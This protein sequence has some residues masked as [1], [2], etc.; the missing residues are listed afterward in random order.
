MKKKI[1]LM[2]V[3]T[4]MLVLALTVAVSADSV[5]TGKVDLNQKVTLSD[6]TECALFDADGD[7]LIWYKDANGALQSIKAQDE[8][9][10][11]YCT[12]QFGVGNS[13]VGSVTVYE[14]SKIEIALESGTLPCSS[15]VVFNI[16]D[17]DVLSNAGGSRLNNPVNCIRSNT[18][19][20]ST[21]LEYAFLRLD[22]G[23]IQA[24]AFQGCSNLKYVNLEHLTELRQFGGGSCFNNCKSFMV[25]EVLDLSNTKL[26]AILGTGTFN[27]VKLK[28]IILP[29]TVTDLG[30]WNLQG[31]SLESFVVPTG[32]TKISGST[33]N[34]T[35]T[36]KTIYI[37]NT[38]TSI[39]DRA[40]NNTGLEKIFYVGTLDQLN[41]LLAKASKTSNDPFWAVVGENNA[42]VISYADYKN[43]EDKSGKYV[44][45]NY[46][47]CEAYNKSIHELDPTKSNACAGICGLCGE[48]ALAPNPVHDYVTTIEYTNYLAKGTRTQTCQNPGC[49]HN[50]APYETSA[51]A[52]IASFK[53]FSTKEVGDGLTFGYTLNLEAIEE[54][55]A[56]S[57]KTLEFG[58]VVA[59]QAFLGDNAPLDKDGNAASDNVIKASITSEDHTY[60]GADFRLTSTSW[61]GTAN[62]NGVETALKDIKF[63]MAGYIIDGASVVY[64]NSGATGD[65][66]DALSYKDVAGTE[67]I[68]EETPAE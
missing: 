60:T 49:A 18:F 62:I 14:I 2:L 35:K 56:V 65:K 32:V 36:L 34:D 12:Y 46:N 28:G 41:T 38:L 37:N 24:S 52:I 1:F 33:F 64:I 58:F 57:G 4:V 53:G 8:R 29:N 30:D 22:T 11:F 16:M 7:A 68:P 15:I 67:V 54:Y 19:I 42:N 59:V 31:M 9:V 48:T 23:A 44:V 25:G 47:Y 3:M 50:T 13:V 17:D 43:L 51:N 21:N 45:Y 39:S 6:G 26:C 55:E 20:N 10:L 61:D 27:N 5:H 40:F 66:A 63:Y